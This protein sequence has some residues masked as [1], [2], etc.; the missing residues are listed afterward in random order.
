MAVELRDVDRGEWDG[1]LGRVSPV[2]LL[3]SWE[4]GDAKKEAEV[5]QPVRAAVL[6]AGQPVGL[7]QALVKRWPLGLGLA[8]IN[9][10]PLMFRLD[11]EVGPEIEETLLA[12]RRTW[13]EERRCVL[14]IAPNLPPSGQTAACLRRLGFIPVGSKRGWCSSLVALSTT[15]E[16]LRANLH[17]K[18][19]NLL[20]KSERM[21]VEVRVESSDRA[22]GTLLER[23][24]LLQH[25]K[26]F[27][28]I[29]ER[30]I[31]SL[32]CQPSG[33]M[34]IL[35]AVVNGETVAG[36]LVVGH[37][38]TCTYLVSWNTPEGRRAA[39]N[40]SLLWRAM[41]LF[42]ALG[43]RWLDLGGVDDVGSPGVAHFKRG[44]NGREY[45][46]LGEYLAVRGRWL[47]RWLA[48]TMGARTAMVG[49]RPSRDAAD[50]ARLAAGAARAA[51]QAITPG[52]GPK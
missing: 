17:G 51:G 43:Y 33:E 40:Y 12:I 22:L 10:G 19:R 49:P 35:S 6:R 26:R 34:R 28:G 5:W 13:V 41:L 32:K 2:N 39:A 14:S 45:S 21:G 1:L 42:K 36:M 29:A 16:G 20:V 11:D 27:K 18:W 24:R 38:D 30:L 31:R 47:G 8:R 7:V 52:A 50:D 48:T 37:A 4:Y 3:Q 23:H 46:L 44:V 15:E 9:R 25:A